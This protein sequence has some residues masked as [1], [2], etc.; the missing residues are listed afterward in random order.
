MCNVCRV[1]LHGTVAHKTQLLNDSYWSCG[2]CLLGP[3][4][5]SPKAPQSP[6]YPLYAVVVAL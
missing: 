2:M 3:V 1:F 5:L 6:D 4:I